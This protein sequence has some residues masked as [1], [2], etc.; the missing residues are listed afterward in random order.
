MFK[1]LSQS[2]NI[3][4]PTEVDHRF[5]TLVGEVI[6]QGR[7]YVPSKEVPFKSSMLSKFC[8]RKMVLSNLTGVSLSPKMS[9]NLG[10]IFG[11]GTA[12]HSHFQEAIMQ[13]FGDVFQ[14]WWRC[15]GCGKIHKGDALL[16]IALSHKWIPM[17]KS[18]ECGIKLKDAHETEKSF[19]FEYMELS[20][21]DK[22]TGTKGHCDGILVWSEEEV[23]VLELKSTGSMSNVDPAMGGEPYQDH[24]IQ[25]HDYMR[26]AGLKKARIVYLNKFADSFK[27]AI[28]E[29]VVTAKPKVMENIVKEYMLTREIF[30]LITVEMCDAVSKLPLAYGKPNFKKLTASDKVKIVEILPERNC[31]C[32]AKT[33][34]MA[35]DC[36]LKNQ[37]FIL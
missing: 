15:K 9:E 11:I 22:T 30:E 23:E 27:S 3:K 5:S 2:W 1:R 26:M 34:K 8:S 14:G 6:S 35:K 24:K 29:H 36:P 20:F 17:P 19:K 18:C 31:K 28:V 4:E 37:C 33:D 25:V 10:W 32:K 7:S 16:C 12:Y 21:H 13:K